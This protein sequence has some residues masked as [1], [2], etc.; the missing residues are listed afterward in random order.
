MQKIG[1]FIS[2]RHRLFRG[3][4]QDV[5]SW[6]SDG[7]LPLVE[8]MLDD[9]EPLLNDERAAWFEVRQITERFGGLRF[10]AHLYL[11]GCGATGQRE[12]SSEDAEID[13]AIARLIHK[14]KRDSSAICEG[15]GVP[16]EI[17]ARVGCLPTLCQRCYEA[18][19]DRLEG[20]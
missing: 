14:A 13:N 16:R 2:R 11:P 10:D 4:C 6:L 19:T 9:I 20:N 3:N 15:C 8:K 18:P 5:A 1:K 7:W 12:L 17:R